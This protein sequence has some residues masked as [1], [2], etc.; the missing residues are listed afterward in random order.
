[1][2]RDDVT[3]MIGATAVA[4][5]R[6]RGQWVDPNLSTLSSKIIGPGG[7]HSLRGYYRC[8]GASLFMAVLGRSVSRGCGC[9]RCATSK[10]LAI[11]SQKRCVRAVY[12]GDSS[13]MNRSD[14]NP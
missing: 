4:A 6:Y 7:Y 11:T 8:L 10:L 12:P 13:P 5:Y 9:S 1:M 14:W 3:K 2:T